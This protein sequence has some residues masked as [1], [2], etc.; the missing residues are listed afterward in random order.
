MWHALGQTARAGAISGPFA[1]NPAIRLVV[2]D[3]MF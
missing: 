1:E 3:L 2:L